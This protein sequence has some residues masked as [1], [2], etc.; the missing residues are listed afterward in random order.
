MVAFRSL[1][2][3]AVFLLALGCQIHEESMVTMTLTDNNGAAP[4][5]RHYEVFAIINGGAVSLIK[6][7][8]RLTS[9]GGGAF[10][11]QVLNHLNNDHQLGVVDGF[12]S[13]PRPV[14]GLRFYVPIDLSPATELFISLED[15][16]DTDPVPSTDVV[17]DCKLEAI[18]RG[19]LNCLLTSTDDKDVVMGSVSLVLPD[20]GINSF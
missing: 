13:P 8:I 7:D 14:G 4:E 9:L 6:F 5:G 12:G 19:T 20:D 3:M 16:G 2:L 1:I 10:Q 18:T 17:M 15:D 11:K